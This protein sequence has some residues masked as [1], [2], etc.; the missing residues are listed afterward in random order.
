VLHDKDIP[1][2]LD[3][4]GEDI[5]HDWPTWRKMLPHFISARF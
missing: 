4:W 3:I 1:H 5:T 2:E